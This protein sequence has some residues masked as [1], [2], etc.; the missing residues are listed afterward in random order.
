MILRI[1]LII[2]TY[3]NPQ[4]INSVVAD[5]LAKTVFP[6]LIF[7]DGSQV[8][9][10]ELV[11]PHPRVT[12]HRSEK[13]Q[14]KGAAL[15]LAIRKCVEL[16]FT[17]MLTID[18]DGQHLARE[19]SPLVEMARLHPW[20]LIIGHRRLSEAVEAPR[21]SHF[22]KH[23]S[24]FWVQFQTDVKVA[25]SQSGFRLY[26][27]F[28]LQ[29]MGFW[30]R[31]FD[32][33][34]EVLIRLLWRGV[35]VREV[36][37]DVYYPPPHERVSHFDK[38]WD[39]VRI[40]L[41][42]TILVVLSLLKTH[43]SPKKAAIAVGVGTFIG[44]TPLFGFHTFLVAGA[45]FLF[46]L[47]AMWMLLGSQI[48]LPFIAPFLILASLVIG[49]FVLS[50]FDANAVQLV[51]TLPE[52]FTALL[53][54]AAKSLL[55]WSIGS[56]FLGL[57]VGIVTGLGTYYALKK[58]KPRAV[59]TGR[60]RGGHVGNQF[61]KFVLRHLGIRAGYV[62][63]YFII[64]YFY[65]FA[66]Q[67]RSSANQ[68][69]QLMRPSAGWAT[70]Q[71][72]VCRQLFKFGQVLLDR[73]YQSFSAGPKFV[74]NPNGFERM[75]EAWKEQR[76]LILLGSHAGGWDLSA[77]LLKSDG[78]NQ[79]FYMTKFTPSGLTF[80]RFKE[81]ADSAQI[82]T[83]SS[84]LD[85]QPI[86]KLHYLLKQGNI[87]GL[88]GDRPL[89]G[90]HELVPFLGRLAVFDSTPFWIASRCQCPVIVTF[91]FKAAKNK[92]DFYALPAL[93]PEFFALEKSQLQCFEF[94]KT[95]SE[96]L[97]SMLKKYP[98]QWFNFYPFWS[99]APAATAESRPTLETNHLIEELRTPPHPAAA[100]ETATTGP[101]G[102]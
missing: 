8:P 69:W 84:N 56:I 100:S 61:L 11:A 45:A 75:T 102:Q 52:D 78:L 7:D 62:C 39:N 38:L 89:S 81:K 28:H 47:N 10:S 22:G 1:A 18:G 101:A 26:P 97:A 55:A 72:L 94:L 74:S 4:M 63:L 77:A 20:S 79:D 67:S 91:G 50:G 17:H 66:P 32:F 71:V 21:S 68:Y 37:I 15:Q 76:G 3:N 34:I 35:D 86:M 46:R 82:K 65:L 80:D 30:T 41:L 58:S 29:T 43:R 83:V 48:S 64:P 44:C 57:A 9:V 12:I 90:R 36:D 98:D 13:N 59:W 96:N 5:A 51:P 70:R 2:P 24:N 19:C 88:M 42:N 14:G 95:Y 49:H 54:V 23:F 99:T 31:S 6:I 16:G 60:T 27:L 40:S 33:E 53:Y 25:D 92:Y 93:R 87:V 73:I 85:S